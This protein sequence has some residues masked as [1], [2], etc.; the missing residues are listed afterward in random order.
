MSQTHTNYGKLTENEAIKPKGCGLIF[1]P[2][3][4]GKPDLG[5]SILEMLGQWESGVGFRI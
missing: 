2:R 1:L 4:K 5:S 3:N